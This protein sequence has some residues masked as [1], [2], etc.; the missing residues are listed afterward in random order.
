V[1]TLT[2]VG[3]LRGPEE[4]SQQRRGLVRRAGARLG[5]SIET[6]INVGAVLVD[7]RTVLRGGLGAG[8]ARR[9]TPAPTRVEVEVVGGGALAEMAFPVRARRAVRWTAG[10]HGAFGT[11]QAS[12]NA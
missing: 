9:A 8:G 1:A 2:F 3:A 6:D 10:C 11:G 4:A 7:A 5:G 12:V